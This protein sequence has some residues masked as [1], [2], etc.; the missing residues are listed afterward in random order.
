MAFFKYKSNLYPLF[1][2]SSALLI[3]IFG[4][5]MAKTV[6]CS[7]FLIGA[8][9][10]LLLFGCCRQ[11]IKTL[12]LFVIIGGA[13]ALIA[14]YSSGQNPGSALALANRFGAVFLALV[15]GMSI[16]AVAM[17]RNLSQLHMPRGITLGMLI[18]MSFIPVLRG[19]IK[20][21]REAM[22]TRGAGS[23]LNP[24]IFYRA[25]LIPL[26]TRL[27]DISDTLAL[28]I[29]TRGFTLGK[30]KYTVYKKEVVNVFDVL[31]LLGLIAGVVLVCML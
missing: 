10:W 25:F 4:L 6:A 15:P 1:A 7:Y 28:S 31:Y 17:T 20:R 23:I 16:Q 24:K 21:V 12:P 14:Y 2:I 19:E 9:V 26:V 29:E 5:I 18:T 8:F 11:A 3:M 30:C 27:V 13:F 22:K